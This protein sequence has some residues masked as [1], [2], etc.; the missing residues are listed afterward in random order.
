MNSPINIRFRDVF[1]R[2]CD[3][4]DIINHFSANPAN[5][6]CVRNVGI[7]LMKVW[8]LKEDVLLMINI[9]VKFWIF[10]LFPYK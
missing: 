1:K 2:V 4:T 3:H 9:M 5:P 6:A 7:I 8:S 10:F